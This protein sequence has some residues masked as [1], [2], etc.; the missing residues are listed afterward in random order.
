[1]KRFILTGALALLAA[2]GL[3]A[4]NY[5]LVWLNDD[6]PAEAVALISQ[7]T[8]QMLEAGGLSLSDAE[9]AAPLTVLA[10]VSS[11]LDNVGSMNQVALNVELTFSANG[12]SETFPLKGV[13]ADDA[14]AWL[15]AAKQFLPKSKAASAFVAQLK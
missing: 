9:D 1:M 15:R 5:K 4:Q 7:R 11:R 10:Q 12:V 6:A 2:L 3:Q 14:D 8:A 13:G